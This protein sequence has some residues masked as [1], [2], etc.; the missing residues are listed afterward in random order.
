VSDA[1]ETEDR[2][3]QVQAD[4]KKLAHEQMGRFERFGI[5]AARRTLASN[6]AE[7]EHVDRVFGCYLHDKRGI[8]ALSE[9]RLLVGYG[10]LGRCESIE[11][12]SI[13]QVNGKLSKV[14]I[15][16]PGVSMKLEAISVDEFV[17]ALDEHR[18]AASAAAEAAP[19][20]STPTDDPM[21]LIEQLGRLKEQG[22]LTDEEFAA[23]KAELLARM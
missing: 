15:S 7:D 22:L 2:E 16:G 1:D 12:P 20:T 8:A 10:Q 18:R 4:L 13:T 23:K 11:Y 19:S 14:E 5:G 6:V 3:E 9:R 21:A 17:K